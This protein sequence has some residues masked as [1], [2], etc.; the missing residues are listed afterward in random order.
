M[1]QDSPEAALEARK[2]ELEARVTAQAGTRAWLPYPAALR[3]AAESLCGPEW[4]WQVM[5][6][7]GGDARFVITAHRLRLP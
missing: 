4:E 2:R 5:E 1:P 7:I 6:A 3:Q